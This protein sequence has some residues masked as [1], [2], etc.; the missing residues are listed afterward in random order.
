MFDTIILLILLVHK[1]SKS[2]FITSTNSFHNQISPLLPLELSMKPQ[3]LKLLSLLSNK[4]FT[5]FIPPFQRNYEW[6]NEQCEIFWNDVV[7]TA[8]SNMAGKKV[9]HFFGT[10]TYYKGEYVFPEP[11]KLILIDG[12]QRITTTMLFLMAIRDSYKV[13]KFRNPINMR[14]LKND[15]ASDENNEYRIKLKQVE[16]DWNIFKKLVLSENLTDKEKESDLYSNYSFF[17]KNLYGNLK[18]YSE[19]SQKEEYLGHIIDSGLNNFNI[20][21]IELEPEK[22]PGENPQEIFESMNSIGKPL[23]LADLVRNYLLLGLDSKKQETWYKKYWL[24]IEQAVPEKVSAFIRDY[25]QQ[26]IKNYYQVANESNYKRLYLEFKSLFENRNREELLQQLSEYAKIYAYILGTKTGNK[27]IDGHL[28]DFRT[29]QITTAYSFLLALLWEWKQ[30]NITDNDIEEILIAFKIY[31]LRR[32]LIPGLTSGENKNF[33]QFVRFIPV[34]IKSSNKKETLFELLSKEEYNIRLPNDI[35]LEKELKSISDFYH[36]KQCKF[37]LA[38]IEE[39]LTKNRPDISESILQVEHIMPQ[40]LNEK[41]KR[42]LGQDDVNKHQEF[43]HTIGNLTLIRH[44]QELGNKPFEEKKDI[45][46]NHA[47]LQIAKSHIIDQQEWNIKTIEERR[48]WLIKYLLTSVLPI[49]DEK[50][51]TNN[52]KVKVHHKGKGLSF[53][54]LNLIGKSI[55]Y[56][57]DASI[58][59]KV[60]SDKEVEFEGKVWKLSPLTREIRT[61]K[62]NCNKSGAYQGANYWKYGDKLLIDLM[63]S[64]D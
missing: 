41:W 59:A 4:D 52:Y 23:S 61:R 7:S 63:Q 31:C 57:E 26:Y 16:T 62:G 50:R 64:D 6:T 49:P 54:E 18:N 30:D 36:V 34:L 58:V 33:P 39:S 44:N 20:V 32:R 13:D 43:V 19:E 2:I 45:Y 35:E 55:C 1:K 21:T 12:Q 11:D 14:F 24:A 48:D 8:D 3:E 51:K 9:Q 56:L 27:K 22:N 5:F 60:V 15:N 17:L 40:T 25:M 46:I 37:Y 10:I 29:L 38:L 53:E 28:N 42:A 47:G